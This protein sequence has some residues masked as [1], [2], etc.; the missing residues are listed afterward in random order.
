MIRR[1][2]RST[3]T[4]TLFPY[5]TLVR[6]LLTTVVVRWVADEGLRVDVCS[7]GELE[8]AL[9]AGID[10]GLLGFHGNNKSA[11][12]LERAVEVGVGTVIVDSDI[13]VERLSA[14]A[15]RRGAVQPVL[16]RVRTGVHAETTSFHATAPEDHKDR[17]RQWEGKRGYG[18]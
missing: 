3:R 7:L 8:V 1:P 17:P 16:V 2:P 4:D 5:T 11:A 18:R 9:A 14:V 15:E 12:A 13:A 10:P 6:S